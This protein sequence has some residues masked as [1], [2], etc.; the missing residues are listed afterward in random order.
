MI[1]K[2][3]ISFVWSYSDSTIG[4]IYSMN[5]GEIDKEKFVNR[6]TFKSMSK[7]EWILKASQIELAG[8]VVKKNV[9]V[10]FLTFKNK[11]F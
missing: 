1:Q 3:V 2:P 5:L 8:I 7:N 9:Y 11:T 10:R 4:A 6:K